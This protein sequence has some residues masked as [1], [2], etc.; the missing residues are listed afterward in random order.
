MVAGIEPVMGAGPSNESAM[1]PH[2]TAVELASIG[3]LV[4]VGAVYAGAS[5]V[6]HK[7]MDIATTVPG[8]LAKRVRNFR[9]DLV[10][11]G[12]IETEEAA[13]APQATRRNGLLDILGVER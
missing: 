12:F 5:Y 11:D 9:D 4:L 13:V 8:K 2:Y 3:G 1:P 7:G 6:F 10:S